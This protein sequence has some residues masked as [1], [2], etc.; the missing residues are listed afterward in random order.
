M[1]DDFRNELYAVMSESLDVNLKEINNDTS[2]ENLSE[3]DSL[4]HL[5]VFLALQDNFGV[6]FTTDE[7]EKLSS[8]KEIFEH[9]RIK[10]GK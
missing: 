9:L 6:E 10:L 3:W 1:I 5:K 2:R 4:G 7:I 8:V